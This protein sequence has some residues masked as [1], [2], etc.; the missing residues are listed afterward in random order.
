MKLHPNLR[1]AAF[2]RR[3]N[4]F[5]ALMTIDGEEVHAHVANSG[6]LSELLTVENTMLLAPAPAD[7]ERK[8]AYDLALVEVDN[9]LVSA[10]ARLPNRIVKEAIERGRIATLRTYPELAV[11][12]RYEDSRLDLMLSGPE[13]RCYVEVKSVTLVEAGIAL[14]PDAPTERGRKHVTTLQR[15]KARGHR[16]VVIF[17]VQRPDANSFSPNVDADPRF[18]EALRAAITSGVEVLAYG[19]TVS[20]TDIELSEPLPLRAF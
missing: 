3:L 12:V 20:R 9:V 19:C 5:A 1:N 16:A 4:R 15:A 2:V 13:G 14:F 10:D 7:T 11:E 17:V 8:T 6:R 18:A